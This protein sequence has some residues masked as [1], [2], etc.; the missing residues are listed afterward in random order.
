MEKKYELTDKIRIFEGRRL[1]RI[2]ALKPFKSV[3]YGD[4]GGWVEFEDN[5]SQFGDCWLYGES[6]ACDCSRVEGNAMLADYAIV[7]QNADVAGNAIVRDNSRIDGNAYVAGRT[8]IYD[9][10]RVG[11]NASIILNQECLRGDA[12]INSIRDYIVF[13]NWW[14]SGRYFVWTRS[15]NKWSVGC[16]YGSGKELIDRAYR[17]S[18]GSG[19]EYKRIVKYVENKDNIFTRMY[20]FLKH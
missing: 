12:V 4:L 8:R 15:N 3:R 20:N 7:S 10:V 11:G 6:V 16:F 2:R 1:H 9:N 13:K 17:D 19:R 5:L 14:S 18:K